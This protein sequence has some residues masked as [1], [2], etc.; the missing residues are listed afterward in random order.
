MRFFTTAGPVIPGE[1]YCIPPLTRFDLDEILMLIQQKKYFVLHAPRQVGKTSYLL[2][3]M[4]YL[5]Q[6]DEYACLYV[7]IENAQPA[8]ENIDMA[9]H[10]ILH[11]ISLRARIHLGDLFPQENVAEVRRNGGGADSVSEILT[12]WSEH[13]SKPLILLLDEVDSLIGDSLISLLR[14]LRSGYDRR[15]DSFPHS[16]ILCGVRDVRDYRIHSSREKTTITGGSAFNVKAE[17]LRMG[18]FIQAEVEQLYNQHTE[19]TGQIF[20]HGALDYVWELTNGQPWL[21]NALGYEVCFKTKTHRDRSIAITPEMIYEAKENLILRRETH[22]DQL[23]D[24]L[25]EG[26]VQRVIEPILAGETHPENVST[27]DIQY[28]QDLGLIRRD[29]HVQIANKIYQEVIPRELTYSTQRTITNDSSWYMTNDGQLDMSKLLGEFQSYFRE[30]SEHWVER[31]EYKEAGPQLLLQAFLQRV[32]NGGGRIE[33]EYGLGRRR[34]DLLIIWPYG[35]DKI[36]KSVI[37]L[38]IRYGKLE[39]TIAEGVK[40]TWYYMDRAETDDG[41]LVI[42]DR[43]PGK[44]WSEKIF[45]IAET[46]EDKTIQVWGM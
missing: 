17:S 37:E 43:R 22:L 2:A 9:M 28:V 20:T 5:N 38:K 33:R 16:I 44:P 36:Q 24:K 19:E 3:L 26:R 13:L 6:R 41:H 46:L 4:E 34:T 21:V 42:F 10:S 14:Q 18:D 25:Q 11:Q 8:R 27:D 7:N 23:A 15:G 1:H 45:T 31:F 32:I 35:D 30:H 39:K 12:R 40:Q 29:G